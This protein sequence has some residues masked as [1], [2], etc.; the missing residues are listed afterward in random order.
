MF[1]SAAPLPSASSRA[2]GDASSPRFRSFKPTR[3]S[4]GS[5]NMQKG[6]S[7]LLSSDCRH[8]GCTDD[9]ESSKAT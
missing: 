1:A 9:S 7:L 3:A 4:S 5:V 6:I 2:V 8:S